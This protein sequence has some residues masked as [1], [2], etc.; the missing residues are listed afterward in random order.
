MWVLQLKWKIIQLQVYGGSI[1]S[2]IGNGST[3]AALGVSDQMYMMVQNPG[4]EPFWLH[5]QRGNSLAWCVSLS[6]NYSFWSHSWQT[7]LCSD[8]TRLWMVLCNRHHVRC[9]RSDRV[10]LCMLK[11]QKK[12]QCCYHD[13]IRPGPRW[14][15][16]G[17]MI[18]S[19]ATD[20]DV[21]DPYVSISNNL[22]G[23]ELAS[24]FSMLKIP[25]CNIVR[26][27][28]VHSDNLDICCAFV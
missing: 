9:T 6:L 26:V 21:F 14:R 18:S 27:L 1:V 16:S 2:S 13:I 20:V 24:E 23:N 17:I 5:I 15:H 8:I 3:S 19:T 12:L 25:P 4:T 11:Y 22:L 7:S 10:Y 28:Y